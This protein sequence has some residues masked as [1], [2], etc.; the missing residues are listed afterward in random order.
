M[1]TKNEKLVKRQT[2]QEKI[3]KRIPSRGL[4]IQ[5]THVKTQLLLSSMNMMKFTL[6]ILQYNC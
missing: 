3:N 4:Q 1:F 5:I 2:G 6:S